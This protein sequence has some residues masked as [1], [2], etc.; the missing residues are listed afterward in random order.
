MLTLDD[1]QKAGVSGDTPRSHAL[2]S[3]YDGLDVEVTGHK[4]GA[5]S[6][7]AI[8]A[9]ATGAQSQSAAQKLTARLMG[10]E[11]EIPD[12]RYAAIFKPLEELLQ[13]PAEPTKKTGGVKAR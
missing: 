12:Y 2:F 3:T 4:D 9:H 6:L 10:H 11:F 7:I 5:R 13:K 8:S 1:V